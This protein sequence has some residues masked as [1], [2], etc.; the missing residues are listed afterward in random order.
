MA[1]ANRKT[2]KVLASVQW[3]LRPLLDP[4]CDPRVL[5]YFSRVY[6]ISTSLLVFGSINLMIQ[7]LDDFKLM[8]EP[9]F[10][11]TG[12]TLGFVKWLSFNKH[13]QLIREIFANFQEVVDDSKLNHRP[14]IKLDQWILHNISVF[15]SKKPRFKVLPE[16]GSELE[17]TIQ[18]Y[19]DINIWLRLTGDV[20]ASFFHST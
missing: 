13:A 15:R 2:M 7:S 12:I 10:V 6:F 3:L 11:V 19:C 20:P 18:N 8:I 16:C 14:D 1:V 17:Q 4:T 5:K 9:G